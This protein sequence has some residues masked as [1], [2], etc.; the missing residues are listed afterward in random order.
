MDVPL[1]DSKRLREQLKAVASA[2]ITRV[3]IDPLQGDASSR[4]YYRLFWGEPGLEHRCILM[5][6][7]HS[8][9]AKLSEEAESGAASEIQEMPFINVQRHLSSCQIAVPRIFH[10]DKEMGWL[11]LEDLGDTTFAE[12][13]TE[14]LHHRTRLLDDYKK[15]ID[16]LIGIQFKAT[17][18]PKTE[19]TSMAHQRCFDQALFEWEFEHFLEYGIEARNGSILPLG[20]KKALQNAFSGIARDLA[21]LPKVFVHRDYHGRNL[22]VQATPEGFKLCVIDFQD[23]L[24]GPAQYDL[25]SLLRDSYIDLPETVVDALFFYYAEKWE[26][27]SG[28]L[29]DRPFF[30]KAFDLMSLQRNLKA[31]GRFVFI[32]RVKK[33]SHLLKYVVPTLVKVRRNLT[34]YPELRQ[35][36]ALL[37]DE[38][39]ELR[40]Q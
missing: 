6:M 5:A 16:V 3:K 13:A 18:L 19:N 2:P 20:K 4:L 14:D 36:H 31:A 35:L 29:L 9:G 24:M 40:V 33:K 30:R 10:Y 15:A 12:K 28:R 7:A 27:R 32:D 38:V 37:A 8:E 34:K 22:M 11:F 23:A 1:L 25:A 21:A 26:A 17:P 39:E